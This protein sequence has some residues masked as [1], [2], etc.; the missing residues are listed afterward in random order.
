MALELSRMVASATEP[1][2]T[3]CSNTVRSI[4][5]DSA[6]W[7]RNRWAEQHKGHHHETVQ[8]DGAGGLTQFI[9]PLLL[10]RRGER[11]GEPGIV[12]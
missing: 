5:P 6:A 2:S 9:F 12:A 7:S 8:N 10:P 4:S 11:P 1:L 3:S